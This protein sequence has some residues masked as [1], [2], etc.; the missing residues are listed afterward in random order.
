MYGIHLKIIENCIKR[1]I[2]PE[3]IIKLKNLGNLR[4]NVRQVTKKTGKYKYQME[5]RLRILRKH[6]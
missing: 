1:N 6:V 3:M 4:K 5:M 2:T